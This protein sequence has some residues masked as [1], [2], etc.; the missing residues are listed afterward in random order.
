MEN[1][2]LHKHCLWDILHVEWDEERIHYKDR[3]IPLREHLSVP[4]KDKIRLRW[5][6]KKKLPSN[7]HG[8]TGRHMVQSY[9]A[10]RNEN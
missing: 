1:I 3:S 9:K 7:V 8:K 6:L 4:L 2:T 5:I 10:V